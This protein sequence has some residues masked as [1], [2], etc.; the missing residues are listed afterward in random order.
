[1]LFLNILKIFFFRNFLICQGQ[2]SEFE[3][4]RDNPVDTRNFI[5][6]NVGHSSKFKSKAF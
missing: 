3:V 4:E 5:K 1:M 6:E 2:D